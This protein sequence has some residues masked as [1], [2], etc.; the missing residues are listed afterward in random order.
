MDKYN[1]Q[2]LAADVVHLCWVEEVRGEQQ[3]P[4]EGRHG[5]STQCKETSRNKY[6]FLC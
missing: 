4:Q 6:I 2:L 1:L 5:E 3:G